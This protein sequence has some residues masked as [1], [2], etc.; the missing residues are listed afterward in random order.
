VVVLSSKEED[1][2]PDITWDEEFTRKLF[3]G[4]NR[5]ILGPLDDGKVSILNDFDEEEEVCEEVTVAATTEVDDA[6]KGGGQNDS[7]DGRSPDPTIGDSS[8]DR[9]KTDSP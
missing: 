9:D 8:S 1:L 3:G 2:I 5:E 4:L 6:H 7:N